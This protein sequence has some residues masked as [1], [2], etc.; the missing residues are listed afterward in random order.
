[1]TTDLIPLTSHPVIEGEHT[2]RS[3]QRPALFYL[4]SLATG[5]RRTMR[6]A[7]DT[8]AGLLSSDQADAE[9]LPWHQLRYEHTTALR[10]ALVERYAPAT[11]SKMLAALRGVLRACRRLELLSG[12]D[13]TRAV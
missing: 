4:A 10:A 9:G 1:M 3:P 7:L 8:I 5:S 6:G 12:D 2:A 11:C 13:Y